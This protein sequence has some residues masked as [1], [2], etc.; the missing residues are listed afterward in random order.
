MIGVKLWLLT[1]PSCSWTDFAVA[2]YNSHMD[3]TLNE[4]NK[5]YMPTTGLCNCAYPMLVDLTWLIVS[6]GDIFD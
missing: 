4:L 3:D 1:N 5:N 2:L 6:V